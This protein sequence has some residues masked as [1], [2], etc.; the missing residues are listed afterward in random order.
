MLR[1]E[2]MRMAAR[3]ARMYRGF[4]SEEN[5]SDIKKVEEI[6]R[7]ITEMFQ[8]LEQDLNVTEKTA[9]ISLSDQRNILRRLLLRSGGI[10]NQATLLHNVGESFA[11]EGESSQKIKGIF[12]K[13]RGILIDM[14]SRL[15]RIDTYA[16]N[17]TEHEDIRN[18]Q[19]NM[20]MLKRKYDILINK[21]NSKK[22]Q[23]G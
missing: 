15:H 13:V 23:N 21:L 10:Y 5:V 14:I 1:K 16:H 12:I 3:I 9:G 11:K 17:P 2:I 4:I 6:F 22:L 8:E 20:G 18:H 19:N 7:N